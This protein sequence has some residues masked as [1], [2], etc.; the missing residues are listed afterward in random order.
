MKKLTG[1]W[2]DYK[3]AVIVDM[4]DREDPKVHKIRSGVQ[5]GSVKGGS[6][7]GGTPWGPMDAV[8]ESK[9]LNRRKHQEEAYFHKI[10]HAI[11]ETDEVLIFGPGEA[12]A[13]LVN[14]IKDDHT[15]MHARLRGVETADSMTL[16]QKVAYVRHFFE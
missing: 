1:I 4:T 14:L 9:Q 5:T 13:G 6:R 12:K 3:E 10:L 15:Q 2:L 11:Q 7:T 8:S 16:N